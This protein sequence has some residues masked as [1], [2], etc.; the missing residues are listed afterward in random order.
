MESIAERLP[1]DL[2]D[3]HVRK[4][5]TFDGR[6]LV[7]AFVALSRSFL[8]FCLSM[9]NPNVVHPQ[10]F[11]SLCERVNTFSA[12]GFP[13]VHLHERYTHLFRS[14]PQFLAALVCTLFHCAVILPPT[15]NIFNWPQSVYIAGHMQ[16]MM[17]VGSPLSLKNQAH[18]RQFAVQISYHL[19]NFFRHTL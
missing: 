6:I 8:V 11:P 18:T 7:P 2:D 5:C 14:F 12:H 10:S 3:I 17:C 13:P 4:T 1:H 15:L 9:A 19:P 16:F